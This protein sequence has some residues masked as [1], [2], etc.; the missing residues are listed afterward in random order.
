MPDPDGADPFVAVSLLT[1]KELERFGDDLKVVY[2]IPNDHTFDDL[3]AEISRVTSDN[4]GGFGR[5]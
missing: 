5:G 3:L 4:K 2:S 1:Q